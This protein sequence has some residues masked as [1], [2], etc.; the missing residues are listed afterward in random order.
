[1][2]DVPIDLEV[3]DRWMTAQGVPGLGMSDVEVLTGGTQNVLVR[4]TRGDKTYVL[5]RPPRHLRPKSNQSLGREVRFLRALQD[6]AVPTPALIAAC[7]DATVLADG[8]SFYVMENID[9]VN[10]TF[11][12]SPVQA[13]QTTVRHEM[14]L[15]TARVL[16]TLGDVDY[17]GLGLADLGRP[18]GFLDRQVPRWLDLLRSYDELDGYGGAELPGV[19]AVADWLERNRPARGQAGIMHGDFHLA[20]ILFT[21]DTSTVAAV[22]DWEMATIGDPL[23]DLGWLLAT[24]PDDRWSGQPRSAIATAGGLPDHDEVIEAYASATSRDV[25]AVGWYRVLACF[26]LGIVL[27]GTYA[28]AQAGLAAQDTGARLHQHATDL[29]EQAS[30]LL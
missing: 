28:R 10:P 14:C 21:P 5:R 15:N 18:E 3:V 20:N 19:A 13:A 30:T 9:G 8:A 22:I 24:W 27:E 1:M 16:A 23:L 26:K 7:E 11:T 29:F 2:A 4:F 25:S 12:L 17:R 6:T